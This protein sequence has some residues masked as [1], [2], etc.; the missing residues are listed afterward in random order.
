MESINIGTYILRKR[1]GRWGKVEAS[2]DV[3]TVW[4]PEFSAPGLP[5]IGQFSVEKMNAIEPG[6]REQRVLSYAELLGV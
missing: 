2:C 5:S 6:L 1:I 3:R 4:L